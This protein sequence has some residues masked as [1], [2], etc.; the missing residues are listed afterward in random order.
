MMK[1][2]GKTKEQVSR[3]AEKK[4]F[5]RNDWVQ[6][7][8]KA[9]RKR[10]K[11]ALQKM[12]EAADQ[13]VQEMKKELDRLKEQLKEEIEKRKKAEAILHKREPLLTERLKEI[14]CLYAI[15]SLLVDQKHISNEEKLKNVVNLLPTGWQYPEDT[16]AQ[17]IF[18]GKAYRT[19]NYQETR[20]KQSSSI[21]VENDPQGIVEVG[22]L[23]E[24]PSGDEG[25]FLMEERTL[26][27]RIAKLLGE[28]LRG[29]QERVA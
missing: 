17:I 23:L 8:D 29:K 27:D 24:K 25:P 20:W 16:Y 12:N 22:Y 21:L 9:E 7:Q 6:I 1:K 14:S 3:E 28:L 5:W 10:V 26:I 19:S 13:R 11:E 15:V 18:E 4:A 2:K